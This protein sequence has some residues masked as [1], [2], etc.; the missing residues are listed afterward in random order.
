[1]DGGVSTENYK[2]VFSGDGLHSQFT[3]RVQKE[4]HRHDGPSGCFSDAL[5]MAR[6]SMFAETHEFHEFQVGI[7][8]MFR[9]TIVMLDRMLCI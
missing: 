8:H 7:Y 3:R 1:M 4:T 9:H 5:R 2:I 6:P